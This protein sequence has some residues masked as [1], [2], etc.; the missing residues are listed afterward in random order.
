MLLVEHAVAGAGTRDDVDDVRRPFAVGGERDGPV[1]GLDLRAELIALD[2][3][4]RE[5]SLPG[6][7]VDT[8]VVLRLCYCNRSQQS[9]STGN[10]WRLVRASCLPIA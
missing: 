8:Q 7:L 3:V 1:A 10:P 5:Q 9:I 6:V 4:R 2:V